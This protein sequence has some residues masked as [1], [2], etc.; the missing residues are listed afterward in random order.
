MYTQTYYRFRW[1]RGL[2]RGPKAA[3]LL[4]LLVRIPAGE[5]MSVSYE[6]WV[7][8]VRGLSASGWSIVQRSPTEFDVFECDREASIMTR[9]WPTMGCRAMGEKN[10]YDVLLVTILRAFATYN[11]PCLLPVFL[12]YFRL[13]LVIKRC[14]FLGK[15]NW[16]CFVNRV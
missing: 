4:G 5:W 16:N 6:C 1:P 14:S 7:L 8:S 3:R 12:L 15:V 13:S 9:Q 11:L 2:R 10:V